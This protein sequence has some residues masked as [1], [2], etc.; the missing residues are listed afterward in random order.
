VKL[1]RAAARSGEWARHFS[2]A[3]CVELINVNVVDLAL[4]VMPMSYRFHPVFMSL[5]FFFLVALSSKETS[6]LESD[7]HRYKCH[8]I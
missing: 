2:N 6:L 1:G 3:S 4:T 5:S 8:K 7:Y